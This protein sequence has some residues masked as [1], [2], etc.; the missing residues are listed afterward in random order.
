MS[1]IDWAPLDAPLRRLA[2]RGLTT[3]EMA[4]EMGVSRNAVQGRC[5]RLQLPLRR[6]KYVRAPRWPEVDPA[7]DGGMGL[8]G[9]CFG[10]ARDRDPGDGGVCRAARPA[11]AVETASVLGGEA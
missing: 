2:A 11:T 8:S 5:R 7:P 6:R 1:R 3:Y 10:G 9:Q 4:C